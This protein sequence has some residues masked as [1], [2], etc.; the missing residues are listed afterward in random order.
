MDGEVFIHAA[1]PG[2]EMIF[3]GVDCPLSSIASVEVQWDQLEVDTF[4]M[5]VL[6]ECMGGFIV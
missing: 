2:S 6:L 5:K 3:E 4:M 1:Q